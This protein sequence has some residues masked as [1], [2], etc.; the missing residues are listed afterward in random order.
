KWSDT[1]NV[2]W[3]CPLPDGAS[4]PAIWGDA[5]FVTGQDGDKLMLFRIERDTGKILWSSQVGTGRMRQSSPDARPGFPRQHKL[6]SLASPSPATDGELVVVHFGNGDLAAYDFAGKQLWKHNL[7]SEN[8][9]YTIWWG[10]ANSPVIVNHLVV[11][12]CMQDSLADVRGKKAADSYLVAHD[13]RT[14]AQRWKTLR[15]TGAPREEADAYTTPLLRTVGD[16]KELVV[17]GGNQLDAYDPA[18]GKQ[19]WHLPDLV[20]GRT[21]TGPTTGAGLIFA[22]RGK[23]EALLAVKASGRDLLPAESIVWKKTGSTADSSSPVYH[24]GLLFW[25]T[26]DGILNCVDATT[27]SPKWQEKPRLPGDYKASPIVA[28]D[29]LY[30]LNLRGQCTVVKA[31]PKYEKLAEN[32]IQDDTIA[33]PAAADG[34]LFIRGRKALYCIKQ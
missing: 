12:V 20:G 10:H 7:Q 3:K 16:R 9:P 29:R 33:S 19:L 17:M 31:G 4:T 15:N 1:D 14:G 27:G 30:F 13:A 21:V 24:D 28:G 8:G 11:S 22:T 2:A 34:R 6:Y 18:T 5:V 25:I 26:D 32:Q 23:K